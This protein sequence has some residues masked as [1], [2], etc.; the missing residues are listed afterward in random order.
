MRAVWDGAR[1]EA[2]VARLLAAIDAGR[3]EGRPRTP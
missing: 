2:A 3:A 1:P